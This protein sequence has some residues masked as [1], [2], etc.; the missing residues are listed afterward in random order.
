MSL[1][2]AAVIDHAAPQE[3][4]E[5]TRTPH[6]L[7]LL[8][9]G[10]I[11]VVGTICLRPAHQRFHTAAVKHR[12]D[13]SGGLRHVEHDA[14]TI[15]VIVGLAVASIVNRVPFEASMQE[16]TYNFWKAQT[17]VVRGSQAFLGNSYPFCV[18]AQFPF[19]DSDDQWYAVS[20]SARQKAHVR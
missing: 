13:R 2:G 17:A 11:A 7:H 14:V 15:R 20:R 3:G 12:G 18:H 8:T 9:E 6:C 4:N 16:H 1:G 19:F 10:S 5:I